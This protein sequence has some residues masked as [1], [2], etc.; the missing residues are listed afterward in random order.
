MNRKPSGQEPRMP[1]SVQGRECHLQQQPLLAGGKNPLLVTV[2]ALKVILP[3]K[4]EI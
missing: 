4:K 1:A 2:S 3:E